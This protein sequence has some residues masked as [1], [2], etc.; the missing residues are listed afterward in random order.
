MK[1]NRQMIM[2]STILL[3]LL[4]ACFPF[5]FYGQSRSLEILVRDSLTGQPVSYVSVWTVKKGTYADGNEF[6]KA[7]I[8]IA[9]NDT[10]QF[11]GVGYFSKWVC[12]NALSNV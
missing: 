2:K 3:L 1:L 4:S 11:S 8:L 6:G 9:P 12:T 5:Y 10:L 7:T